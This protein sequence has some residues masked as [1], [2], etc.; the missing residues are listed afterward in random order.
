MDER[1]TDHVSVQTIAGLLES[2]KTGMGS[3]GCR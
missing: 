2:Q 3:N 1:K